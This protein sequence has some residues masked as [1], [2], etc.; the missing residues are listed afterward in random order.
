[1]PPFN[2]YRRRFNRW[3]RPR[4][5]RR[6]RPRKAVFR[7]YR[8]TKW[9]RRRRK[10]N[11]RKKKLKKIILRQWQP[12]HVKKCKIRGIFSLFAAGYGRYSNDWELYRE[13]L[14]PQGEPG[15]GGW[16]IFQLSLGNLYNQNEYLLNWWTKSNKHLNLCRY[17]S[18]TLRFYRTERTDY[19]VSYSTKYPFQL[20]KYEM[21]SSHPQRL[22][23]YNQKVIVPSFETAPHIK[24]RYYKKKI[25]PPSEFYNKWFFQSDFSPF[26]LVKLTTAACSLN[27]YFINDRSVN[28]NVR[29]YSLNTKIF[30]F[31]NFKE[32]TFTSFGYH[33][34][35]SFYL[36]G[37]ASKPLSG[38][39]KKQDLVYLGNA[40]YNQPGQEETKAW[41]SSYNY[42]KWGN[43]FFYEYL[44]DSREVYVSTVQP[45]QVLTG[46]MTETASNIT[47]LTSPIIQECAYNPF[48]DKGYDNEAYWVDITK[49]EQ[50]WDTYPSDDLIIK[51]FP[52]WILLWGFEDWTRKLQ[53]IHHI[54][55]DYA[56]VV[57]TKYIS[58]SL[59]HY[60]FVSDSWVHGQGPYHQDI[61][62]ISQYHN[63]NWNISWQYQKEAIE[64]ILMSGPGVCKNNFTIHAHMGYSF[65]FKWGGNPSTMESVYDPTTQP[66]YPLPNKIHQ[67]FEI[68]NPIQDP[69]KRLYSFDVRKDFITQTAAK[70][71]K[72]DSTFEPIVFADGTTAT[73][74][75]S[76][77]IQTQTE[78]DHQ[79]ETSEEEKTPPIQQLQ[80]LNQ[81]QQQLQHRYRVLKQ[82]LQRLELDTVNSE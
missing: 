68:E 56:L 40:L 15:G 70:R 14:V 51:G 67:G 75:Y 63:Q 28:N 7:R 61:N 10:K 78:Q 27:N 81:L 31:K 57:K 4:W 29:L 60:I 71:L 20:T 76:P 41:D 49:Q 38:L 69:T 42:A 18:A 12:S 50:G 39:P 58:P 26:A 9:V 45:S 11:I 55:N 59:P 5:T 6:R 82:T 25:Y 47:E 23:T 46:T 8:R 43:M 72:T 44:N 37:V 22:L 2:Y 53:K 54:D 13:S 30:T 66:S 64:N 62:E 74:S 73:T 21:A 17:I 79:T 34:K 80:Q 24:K 16:S 19:V 36:Y 1:M 33:P 3:R 65:Y 77:Q 35:P 48:K 52:L 32:Q